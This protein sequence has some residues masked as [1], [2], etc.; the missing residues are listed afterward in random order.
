M[1]ALISGASTCAVDTEAM[2]AAGPTERDAVV[3]AAGAIAVVFGTLAII[4]AI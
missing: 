2:R 1:F 3:G 4:Y